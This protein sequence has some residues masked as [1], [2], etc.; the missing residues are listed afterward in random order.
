MTTKTPPPP[1]LSGTT[2]SMRQA[3]YI[4]PRLQIVMVETATGPI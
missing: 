2:S 3:W 1:P 4:N